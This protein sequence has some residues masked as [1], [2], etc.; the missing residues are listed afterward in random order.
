MTRLVDVFD[1]LWREC[2]QKGVSPAALM[3][4]P[5]AEGSDDKDEFYHLNTVTTESRFAAPSRSYFT[6]V[7]VIMGRDADG[8]PDVVGV[9]VHIP[10]SDG[11]FEVTF[12]PIAEV[13][14]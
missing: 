9:A 14:A 1:E 6:V 4:Q 13:Q 10:E 5:W 3:E 7:P 12:K 8:R 11:S 2:G